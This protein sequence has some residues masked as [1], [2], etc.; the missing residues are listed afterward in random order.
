MTALREFRLP[1]LG[2][3]L[4]ESDIVSWHV[5]AGDRVE[6]NQVIAEVETAK[7]LVDLPSPYAGVV[8]SLH[9]EEGQTVSVGEPLVTFEVDD[10]AAPVSGGGAAPVTDGAAAPGSAEV[11]ARVPDAVPALVGAVAEVRAAPADPTDAPGSAEVP[12]RA[13]D[14]VPALVGAVAAVGAA[15]A[16]PTDAPEPNLVGYGARPD[17]VG[18]PARRPRRAATETQVSGPDVAEAPRRTTVTGERPRSTPPVRALA[19]K[20]GVRIDR[21][22]GSGR[23]GLITR[24]D[25]LAAV[26]CHRDVARR[27]RDEH[28]AHPATSAGPGASSGEKREVAPPDRGRGATSP[29][30]APGAATGV[31]ADRSTGLEPEV[32]PV[33]GVRKHTAAAMVASAFTAPHATVFLTVDVTRSVE[34]LERLRT[35]RLARGA[36]ITVLALAAR[37]LCLVLPRHPALNSAWRDLPDGSAEIVRHRRVHL[38]IAV[39]TD[40]GLVVP[41]VPDAQALDLPDLAVALTDLTTTA[42]DGRTTPERLTGGTISITNVGVFGVDAGT[43][44]LVPGEAAILGL[45][46]V[47]RRPWEHDG[48]VGLRDV[49]TLS[50]S[51]DHRVVDGE[52]G[53]RFLADLGALLEDPALALLAGSRQEVVA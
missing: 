24:D 20:L 4:T 27:P 47:R 21:V 25:V 52:Q 51:F 9:A 2:E 6:L 29:L 14:A 31:A 37:A 11:P 8:A 49:V 23:D 30:S 45:G 7:A 5:H 19:K 44:I 15:P 17:R 43:P 53:A 40:R 38:G 46:A 28:H 48:E 12:A 22:E 33:R 36:R 16:D 10:G 1:D 35:H 32:V 42:R 39:A 26:S 50:L 13:S 18:R 34:L 41:H 3:G